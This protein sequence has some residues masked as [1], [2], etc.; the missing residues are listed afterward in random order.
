MKKHNHPRCL[1]RYVVTDKKAL[2]AAKAARTR[3]I[4]RTHLR[5]MKLLPGGQKYNP[6][7]EEIRA[8]LEDVL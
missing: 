3:L 1:G 5:I 6:W 2:A 7:T 4:N 8:I